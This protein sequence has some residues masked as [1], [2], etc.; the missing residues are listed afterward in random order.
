MTVATAYPN[1]SG[2]EPSATLEMSARAAALSTA[3]GAPVLSL[4]AGEPDFPTPDYVVEAAIRAIREGE[5]R[6]PPAAGIPELRAAVAAYLNESCGGAYDPSRILVSVG[7]KQA[8]FDALFTLFGPGDRVAFC[9]PYW[10][11]YPAMVRLARA[12]PVTIETGPESGFKLTPEGLEE[13]AAEGLSGVLLN[14]PSNPTG[15]TYDAEELGALLDVA[16]A[17]DVWVLS[18][19]IYNEIL[20]RPAFASVAP[21][22]DESAKIVLINGFSK[23][24]AMTGWRVG[25]AAAPG[26]LV[27]AMARLQG[28]VNTN[29]ARPSQFAALGALGDAEARARA[30]GEMT[31]A[32]ERRRDLL[33]DG[34]ASIA[35]LDALEPDGAFYLWVDARRWCEAAGG[36]STALCLDLL[37]NERVAIVPGAAFGTE[38]W[39]RISF[40]ASDDVLDEALERLT[41]AAERLGVA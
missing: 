6:Y 25:Y 21:R 15:A 34:V 29:T 32:F 2:I 28:H 18:D 14:S 41:D 24:Y 4:S 17:H 38:G 40:A 37:E 35:G 7:A 9:A 13:A 31:T 36:G 26:E 12:E 3:D 1:L 39:V 30:I 16:E 23:A 33:L 10:V 5:T 22:A 19:E 27:E 20:Y 8:L 11:S